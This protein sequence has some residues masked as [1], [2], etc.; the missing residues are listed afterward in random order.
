MPWAMDREAYVDENSCWVTAGCVAYGGCGEFA[1]ACWWA[2]DKSSFAPARHRA[3]DVA[4]PRGDQWNDDDN[5][6]NS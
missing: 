2:S 6:H 1:V 3:G 5:Y 4:D